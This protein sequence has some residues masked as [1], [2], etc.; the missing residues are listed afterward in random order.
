MRG[1]L[2]TSDAV[3]APMG[4]KTDRRVRQMPTNR[5]PNRTPSNQKFHS[6]QAMFSMRAMQKDFGA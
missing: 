5:L 3:K 4:A 2:K 1:S 6:A